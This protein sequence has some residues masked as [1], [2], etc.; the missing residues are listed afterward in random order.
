MA[1]HTPSPRCRIGEASFR[2]GSLRI[3]SY[4]RPSKLFT[5]NASLIVG[6]VGVL[7]ERA[8]EEIIGAVT[9]LLSLGSR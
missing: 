4:V 8:F 9:S 2:T 5:A 1:I 6:E 7:T 3:V